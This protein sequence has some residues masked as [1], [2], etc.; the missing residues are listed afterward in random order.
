MYLRCLMVMLF[1]AAGCRTGRSP[2]PSLTAAQAGAQ[3][4]Q[5]ANV[6]SFALYQRQPFLTN[7]PACYVRDHWV[8][9]SRQG[10][11]HCDLE[12]RVELASDGATNAVD[13]KLLDNQNLAVFR[14]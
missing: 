2:G 4:A 9:I 3:M 6:K 8:W 10:A 13:V 11:G 5:L 1:L 12:A 14:W 7:Q